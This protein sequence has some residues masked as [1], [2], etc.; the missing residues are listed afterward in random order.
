MSDLDTEDSDDNVSLLATK[1]AAAGEIHYPAL[2]LFTSV[3]I[4]VIKF[5]YFSTAL[6]AHQ[7]LFSETQADT[8]IKYTLDKPWMSYS[9]ARGLIIMSIPAMIIFDFGIPVLFTYICWKFRHSFKLTQIRIFFGSI[10]E[11]FA[12]KCFWWEIVIILRKLSIALVLQALP[13]SNTLRNGIVVSILAGIHLIQLQLR[14]WKRITENFADSVSAVVLIIAMLYARTYYILTLSAV[15]IVGSL[16]IILWHTWTGVTDYH[17]QHLLAIQHHEL[18][19]QESA[20]G[21]DIL[22]EFDMNGSSDAS[23]AD[24]S[25]ITF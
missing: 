22:Q 6:A 20:V 2:A 25:L 4:S 19:T 13:S 3:S 21:G 24:D 15:F 8:H 16:A 14:P 1:R 9:E 17:K 5:F 23:E 12:V 18:N 10:F 7:Y 11:S